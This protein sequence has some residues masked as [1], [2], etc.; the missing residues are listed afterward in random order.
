MT[1][2]IQ[3]PIVQEPRLLGQTILVHLSSA[4]GSDLGGGPPRQIVRDCPLNFKVDFSCCTS[5]FGLDLP[6]RA[7]DVASTTFPTVVLYDLPRKE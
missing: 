2:T 3:T 1:S 5:P 6:I 4:R 7:T